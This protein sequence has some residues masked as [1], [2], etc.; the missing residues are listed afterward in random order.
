MEM[1][2]C[3]TKRPMSVVIECE[4]LSDNNKAADVWFVQNRSTLCLSMVVSETD[5]GGV[6]KWRIKKIAAGEMNNFDD[7]R[8]LLVVLL[9]FMLLIRA[10]TSNRSRALNEAPGHEAECLNSE[11]ITWIVSDLP[12]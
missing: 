9:Q 7:I 2:D 11:S 12:K 1:A 10:E 6:R 8:F 3:N 4:I 5:L